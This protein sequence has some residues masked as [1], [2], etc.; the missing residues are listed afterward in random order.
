MWS[1]DSQA[2]RS[3]NVCFWYTQAARTAVV[4]QWMM[5]RKILDCDPKD[6]I[7]K[8]FSL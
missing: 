4:G 6:E 7:L 1:T 8:A 2:T 3:N 5:M